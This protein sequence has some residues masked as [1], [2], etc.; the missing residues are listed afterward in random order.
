MDRRVNVFQTL[1]I[2]LLA[3]FALSACSTFGIG[4]QDPNATPQT[5]KQRVA[6]LEVDF[7]SIVQSAIQLRQAGVIDDQQKALLD[8][9]FQSTAQALDGTWTALDV[10]NVATA[11]NK[12]AEVNRLLLEIY[13]KMPSKSAE[14]Q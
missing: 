3:A 5:L 14:E 8:D 1:V 13:A 7:A 4:E 11:E 6:A 2:A 12:I 9:L 10:G